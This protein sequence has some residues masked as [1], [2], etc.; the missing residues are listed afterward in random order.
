MSLLFND[1]LDNTTNIIYDDDD[2]DDDEFYDTE[3]EPS[4][5][6]DSS[7]NQSAEDSII[8]DLSFQQQPQPEQI[9]YA[10]QFIDKISVDKDGE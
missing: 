4:I 7:L 10:V 1:S 6:L 9:F 8:S 5:I 2:D 3:A